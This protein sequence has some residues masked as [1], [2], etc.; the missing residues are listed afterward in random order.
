[1]EP[2]THDQGR[3]D[4]FSIGRLPRVLSY[5]LS[6]LF[7]I[8]SL[9]SDA[10][11]QRAV[12]ETVR[13]E[14]DSVGRQMT[15]NIILPSGYENAANRD[16][17]YPTLYLL[18]G[19]GNSYEGWSRF[20]GVPSYALQYELIIVMPDAGNSFYVNWAE[21]SGGVAN[22]WEDYITQDV[23]GHVEAN[24]PAL[25]QGEAR[26]I[27][28][29]S[30]GGYGALTI[31]LRNPDLFASIGSQSGAFEYGRR[32]AE[33]LRQGETATPPRRYSQARQSQLDRPNPTIDIAGFSSV[34][35]RTPSGQPFVTAAQAEA[36]DP[37]SLV[38]QVP[39]ERL[40]LIQIDC[41]TADGLITTNREFASLL[42]RLDIPF[43]FLQLSGGHDPI[44]WIEAYGYA[45]G[46]HYEAMQ[47]ALGKRPVVRRNR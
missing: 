35:D 43:D 8:F 5:W 7:L 14:A 9:S 13:F 31:G 24:Y 1:V 45:I 23:I 18:H 29:F 42:M 38:S 16:R 19:Y 30:M 25:P 27:A 33:R 20:M 11:A 28:G 2:V 12:V 4:G 17:Q 3:S 46:W 22:A 37:F 44:Y 34:N 6:A 21:S 26:A 15:Y 47:R 36:H 10:R 40:P 39:R 41:G 32:A